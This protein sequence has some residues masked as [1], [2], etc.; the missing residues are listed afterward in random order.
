[1]AIDNPKSSACT[2]AILL[3]VGVNA[4]TALASSLIRDHRHYDHGK[5]RC[6]SEAR[7]NPLIGL[8]A[9]IVW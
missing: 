2:R 1:M 6:E 9:V 8:A 7:P 4:K 5:T 3:A